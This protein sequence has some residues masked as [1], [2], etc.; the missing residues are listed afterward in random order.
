MRPTIILIVGL[1]LIFSLASGSLAQ[2]KGQAFLWNGTHWA[3]VST[4]GKA[5]Y[6]FGVGNLADFERGSN[7]PGRLGC[8]SRAF[9]DELKSKTVM[10]IV[11]V[12]DKF[13]KENPDKMQRSVIEVVLRQATSVCPPE[14]GAAGKKK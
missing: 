5:A 8:I 6:I 9:V 2:E 7:P 13:Y 4:E 11:Q 3:Q 1:A 10:E 14:T 12:V